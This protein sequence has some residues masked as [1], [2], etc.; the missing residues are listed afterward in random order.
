MLPDGTFV[1]AGAEMLYLPYYMGR[2]NVELWGDD[3]LVFRP[4]HWL[5]MKSRPTAY[6]FPVFQ[7]GPRI[8]SSMNLALLE[9]KI[10]V[11]VLLKTFHV[12]IQES[13]RVKD[14]GYLLGATLDMDGGLPLQLAPRAVVAASS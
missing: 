1:P 7:A 2:C 12:K 5:E 10:C 4:E 13:D 3:Q 8:C 6:E 11:S 14:R 9:T